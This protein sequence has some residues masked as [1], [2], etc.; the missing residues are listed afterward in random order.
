MDK[1]ISRIDLE[2][3]TNS[4]VARW[5][6]F[7]IALGTFAIVDIDS[8]RIFLDRNSVYPFLILLSVPGTLA[9][10]LGWQAVSVVRR[11]CIPVGIIVCVLNGLSILV[12]MASMQGLL[13]AQRLI[14]A[15]L[16]F[17]IFFSL[18]LN[19]VEPRIIKEFKLSIFETLCMALILIAA[20]S[21]AI[22]ST[23]YNAWSLGLFLNLKVSGV[24]TVVGLVCL[25]YPDFK[26]YS[27]IQKLYR[28]SLAVVLVYACFGVGLHVYNISSLSMEV[29]TSEMAASLLG[30]MYGSLIALFSIAAGGQ[31]FQTSEQKMFFDWHLIELYAF[32]VLIV[33]PPLSLLEIG[34]AI[35]N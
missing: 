29:V 2:Q 27:V 30:L 26:G 4:T 21:L 17:G 28:T 16:A 12:D 35:A 34:G 1:L 6:V 13:A 9:I 3:I 15:P 11:C 8:G 33:L 22:L 31:S 14:Y 5:I 10:K 25:V 23:N 20:I 7:F 32:F 18:L 19:L 24:C